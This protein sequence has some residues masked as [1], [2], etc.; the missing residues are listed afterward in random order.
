MTWSEVVELDTYRVVTAD[1]GRIAVEPKSHKGDT[2]LG[3]RLQR[4]VRALGLPVREVL[5]TM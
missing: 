3:E 5:T 1:G 2:S 4:T